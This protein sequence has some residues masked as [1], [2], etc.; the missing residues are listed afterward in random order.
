MIMKKLISIIF[1][2]TLF[3]C[4][5]KVINVS[6]KNNFSIIDYETS[7]EKKINYI[8]KN[9]I[10]YYTK[11]NSSKEITINISSKKIRS[12]KE[13]NIKNEITKF[14]ITISAD[15]EIYEISKNNTT[16]FLI[17]ET[18]IYSVAKQNSQTRNNEQ[19]LVNLLSKELANSILE[20]IR[21]SLNDL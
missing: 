15:V 1:F 3:G 7:G 2:L 6:E 8:I 20:K 10:S 5:F 17:T 12:I 11:S 9:R 16:K 21:I 18:G 14:N 19:N 4:G 13:K